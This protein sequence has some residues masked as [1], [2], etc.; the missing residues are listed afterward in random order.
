MGRDKAKVRLGART[1]LA[2]A[3]TAARR[4]GAPVCVVRRDLVP[5]CGPLGGIYTALKMCGAAAVLFLAVDMPFVSAGLL[6][7][8]LRALGARRRAVFVAVKGVAGF[9]LVVR[10]AALPLVEAQVARGEFSLQALARVLRAKLVEPKS[11]EGEL[12]NINTREE[13]A[14]ASRRAKAQP[15]NDA[16]G[17]GPRPRR[18]PRFSVGFR[19]RERRRCPTR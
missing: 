17:G 6:Q 5:Q 4:L 9:P 2:H 16:T 19:G 1:L 3:R 10:T 8:L 18:H 14:K 13:L 15:F 12:I 11:R 7:E